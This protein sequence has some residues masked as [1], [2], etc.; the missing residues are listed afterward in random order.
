MFAVLTHNVDNRYGS[1][2]L[3]QRGILHRHEKVLLRQ[4]RLQAQTKENYIYIY[5]YIYML[6]FFNDISGL[7]NSFGIALCVVLG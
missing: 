1:K 7:I 5:I 3:L 6:W 4:G 2:N